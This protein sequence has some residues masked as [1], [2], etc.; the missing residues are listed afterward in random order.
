[1]TFGLAYYGG[2]EAVYG[3]TIM[4]V[5]DEALGAQASAGG[6]KAARTAY[7][8]TDFRAI[9]PMDTPI[10]VRAWFHREEGRKRYVNGDMWAGDTLCAT[11]EGLFVE[12]REGL[13]GQAG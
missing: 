3:G 8:K 1:V 11:A 9:L 6:R 4:T 13:P 5:F 7:L 2:G 10:R 12:M